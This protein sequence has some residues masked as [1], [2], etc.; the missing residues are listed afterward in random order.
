[1]TDKTYTILKNDCLSVLAKRFNVSVDELLKLNSQ[2]I[3][4]PNLIYEGDVLKLPED[5]TQPIEFDGS[6]ID[7][8]EPPTQPNGGNDTCQSSMKYADILYVPAHPKTGKQA[9]YALTEQA[10]EKIAI[11]RANIAQAIVK[12][13]VEATMKNLNKL[14]LISKFSAKVHEQFMTPEEAEKYKTLLLANLVIKNEAFR[15]DGTNPNDFLLDVALLIGVPLEETHK[16]LSHREQAKNRHLYYGKFGNLYRPSPE[17][18]VFEK[19]INHQLRALVIDKIKEEIQR[20]EKA[21]ENAAKDHVADDG[22]KFVYHKQLKYFTST[23]Q[24]TLAFL[25][26]QMHSSRGHTEQNLLSMGAQRSRAY[27]ASWPKQLQQALEQGSRM[28]MLSIQEQQEF[29]ANQ[30]AFVCAISLKSLNHY[31]LVIKEQC[32]T[33]NQLEGE[34]GIACGPTA[35]KKINNWRESGKALDIINDSQLIENLYVET[36]G[37]QFDNDL[38]DVHLNRIVKGPAAWSYFT[39]TALSAVIDATINKH[40]NALSQVLGN[41]RSTPI[42]ELFRQLLWVKKLAVARLEYLKSLA[43]KRAA[44]GAGSLEFTLGNESEMPPTLTLLW[45]ETKY[46]PKEKQKSG[47]INK[48]GANDLQAVECCLL[49]DK[50]V[51]YIRGPHWLIPENNEDREAAIAAGHVRVITERIT[52]STAQSSGKKI[53]E[54]GSLTDALNALSKPENTLDLMPIKASA[55]F[56]TAFWQD[57]YH[58]QG[59]KGPNGETSAY[60]VDA[61]AQLLRLSTKAEADLNSPVSTYQ[62][63]IKKR[64]DIGGSGSI[65]AQF[66]ALQGLLSFAFWLPLIPENKAMKPE[67]VEQ[68]KGYSIN[69]T[70][71]DK[72]SREHK[73]EAGDLRVCI[74]GSVYGL[75]AASCQLSAKLAIGPS[76]VSDG[77]GIK[78]STIGLLDPNIYDAYTFGGGSLR[79]AEQAAYA[80]EAAISVDAFA[81]VE[82][83][84]TLGAT[85]Y[86]APPEVKCVTQSKPPKPPKKLGSIDGKLSG[87]FGAGYH[88]E[89]RLLVQ[90]GVIILVASAG[91]VVG[92]GCTGKV[93]INIDANA[94]D[95]FIGC[96]LGVLKQSHFR[97]LAI[98]GEADAN[99][100]NDSFNE[101]NSLMTIALGMGLSLAQVSLMP[102]TA[103]AGYKQ[104]VLSREYAPLLANSVLDSKKQTVTQRWVMALPPETLSNLFSSLIQKQTSSRRDSNG[105]VIATAEQGNESQAQAIVQIMQWLSAD[106]SVGEEA[107]QRQ[108]KETLIAMGKLPAGKKDHQVEWQTYQAQ[109]LRLARFVKAFDFSERKEISKDFNEASKI[110][111]KNMVLTRYDESFQSGLL[112][113]IPKPTQYFAYPISLVQNPVVGQKVQIWLETE[114]HSELVKKNETIINWSIHEALS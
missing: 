75:A 73:Y 95:E 105:L 4:D 51:F 15:V 61:G 38:L 21:A 107:N 108:W 17:G 44:Q 24:N 103:L 52:F 7:L 99:G 12:N 106:K 53:V 22:S 5:L 9:W 104:Q 32:L 8:V 79:S 54:V 49:S 23:H 40:K 71:L 102:V 19:Q 114:S 69:L 84:G 100:I 47:F 112:V 63:L 3:K 1:M 42:D 48:A 62:N 86:W 87:S 27:L 89:F 101:L 70:Y 109:W 67:Q 93:A 55:E 28:T 81:G 43:Q 110:L 96:L 18:P 90:G 34:S 6:R 14:G 10:K 20:L 68:V 64:R 56:D 111:C 31:G 83:G 41:D 33:L 80:G 26:R 92:P 13:D 37:D 66:T 76:D 77:F 39:A 2:Q 58:Y 29:L 45:D 50:K 30:K 16:K 97:R 88:A 11:E 25:I 60:S 85:V 57:S 98:F 82:A 94:A 113:G 59:G 35:L 74:T 91:L 46:E 36:A 78:G 72:H 65:S